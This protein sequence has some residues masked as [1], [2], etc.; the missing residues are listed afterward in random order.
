MNTSGTASSEP[1]PHSSNRRSFL[2]RAAAGVGAALIPGALTLG[3][4]EAAA[5]LSPEESLDY[6]ILNFALNL[7][8]LEAEYYTRAVSGVGIEELGVEV[9][10]FGQPGITVVKSSPKVPFTD[11]NI[12]R[13]AA[14]IAEDER[15]HVTYLRD[16]IAAT[17]LEPAAFPAI[18]LQ[19]SF[20]ILAANAGIISFG[21]T[22][23]PF[24]SDANFLVGA[25]IFEDVGVSAYQGAAPLI[26]S[27]TYLGVAAAILAAEAYHASLARSALFTQGPASQAIAQKIS[28]LRDSLAGKKDKDQGLV[29]AVGKANIVPADSGS[30]VT[31]PRTIRQV[32]NIV[33]GAR[34]ATRGL[35]FPNGVN[36]SAGLEL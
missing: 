10:G 28:D 2:Q 29:D 9:S 7:E 17:G 30:G 33:Y 3:S 8:Y 13:Y 21:Q 18:D 14:E 5:E 4:R 27:K 26:S 31:F 15:A 25:F 11:P 22:F 36:L 24:A 16:A 32:L 6:Y 12:A 35:F 20:S 34:K 1:K 19:T 23:D